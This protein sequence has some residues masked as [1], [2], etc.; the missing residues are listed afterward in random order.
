MALNIKYY[1]EDLS[2]DYGTLGVKLPMNASKGSSDSGLFNMSVTTEEQAISNYVNLLLTRKGERYMQP[3]FGVGIQYKLFEQNTDD[4]RFDIE[5][6]IRDQAAFW[7]PYIVNES[8]QVR[9]AHQIAGLAAD[10]ENG[11]QIVIRFRVNE[12]GANRQLV[13][14]QAAGV[15]NVEI[16]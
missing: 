10:A 15:T 12:T 1:P 9:T 4:L 16:F 7:L 5:N 6:E 14:F 13:I 3:L 2:E 8:I 11:I